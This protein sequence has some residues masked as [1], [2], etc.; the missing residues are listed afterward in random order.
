MRVDNVGSHRGSI[1]NMTEVAQASSNLSVVSQLLHNVWW[2]DSFQAHSASH[3][4][5][6]RLF[7]KGDAS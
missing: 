3:V 2:V 7:V 5:L 4:P 6:D 1:L